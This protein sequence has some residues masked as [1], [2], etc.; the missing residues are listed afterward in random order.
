MKPAG[1]DIALARWLY[2]SLRAIMYSIVSLSNYPATFEKI[3]VNSVERIKARE[4]NWQARQ[5]GTHSAILLRKIACWWTAP[6]P[7]EQLRTGAGCAFL[8]NAL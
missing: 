2:F 8:R 5:S 7:P 6:N 1:E 3:Y 4:Q